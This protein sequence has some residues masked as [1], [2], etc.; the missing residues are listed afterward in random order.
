MWT[1]K[2]AFSRE[3]WDR[4]PLPQPQFYSPDYYWSHADHATLLALLAR[5]KP[6]SVLEFGPGLST[7]TFAEAGV[8]QI[9]T[10]DDQVDYLSRAQDLL[11]QFP[12]ISI[13]LYDRRRVPLFLPRAEPRYDLGFVD[14]PYIQEQRQPEIDYALGRCSAVIVHDSHCRPIV[15]ML[16]A[17]HEERGLTVEDHMTDAP[18]EHGTTGYGMALIHAS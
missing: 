18:H 16:R 15:A 11:S 2:P 8:G 10:Y 4:S 13:R 1:T 14:G 12:Q 6:R 9:D 3:W 17:L 5:L 7:L